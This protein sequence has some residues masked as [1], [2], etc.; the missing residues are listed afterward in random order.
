MS[1]PEALVTAARELWAD[2]AGGGHR[3]D[4][5]VTVVVE[6]GSRLCPDGF[7]GVVTIGAGVF[8]TAKLLRMAPFGP[9]RAAKMLPRGC[10]GYCSLR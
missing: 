8:A 6:P 10:S 5:G 9:T 2:V 4:D 7:V 1:A 3:F